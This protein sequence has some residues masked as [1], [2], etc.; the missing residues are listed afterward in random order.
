MDNKE[1][2]PEREEPKIGKKEKDLMTEEETSMVQKGEINKSQKP[3]RTG[4]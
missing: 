4:I 3:N 1:R 2:T